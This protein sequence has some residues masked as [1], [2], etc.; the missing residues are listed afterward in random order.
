[1]DLE[2]AY[3]GFIEEVPDI[4]PGVSLVAAWK[5]RI[6]YLNGSRKPKSRLVIPHEFAN[7]LS[8]VNKIKN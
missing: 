7:T 6:K 1:M 3:L 4:D 8:H 2:L 5:T